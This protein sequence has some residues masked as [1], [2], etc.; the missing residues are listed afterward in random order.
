[1]VNFI[2][3][4]IYFCGRPASQAVGRRLLIAEFPAQSQANP[5]VICGEQKSTGTVLSSSISAF[6]CQ[7]HPVS[8]PYTY[9]YATR[10]CYQKDK[11]VKAEIFP[12]SN[13]V[14]EVREYWR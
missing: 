11:W 3:L 1:M 7:N 6:S 13:A 8:A 2:Y 9:S 12:N 5:R 10:G 4:F 14:S